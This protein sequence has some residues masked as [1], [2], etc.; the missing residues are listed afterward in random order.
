MHGF[1]GNPFLVVVLGH[2]GLI[3][4]LS[5]MRRRK[6]ALPMLTGRV[7]GAGPDLVKRNQAALAALPWASAVAFIGWQWQQS[8]Q[9]LIPAPGAGQSSSGRHHDDDD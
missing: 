2:I 7:D 6:Q 8:P 5:L 9:G 3:A 4:A 1:F